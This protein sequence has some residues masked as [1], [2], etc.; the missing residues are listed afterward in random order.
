MYFRFWRHIVISGCRSSSCSLKIAS[1]SSP[2]SKTPDLSLEFQ[3][4]GLMVLKILSF[5]VSVAVLIFGCT[6]VSHLFGETSFEH[7][8]VKNFLYC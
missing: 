3:C 7:A 5:P 2:L 6:S 8:V 4:H 1:S